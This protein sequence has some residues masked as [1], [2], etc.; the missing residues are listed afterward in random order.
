MHRG[1]SRERRTSRL[2][3]E[4]GVQCGAGSHDP[5]ITTW[6]EVKSWMP[7]TESCSLSSI[8]NSNMSSI[9]SWNSSREMPWGLG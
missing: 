2:L 1:R 5:E 6:A 9:G 7:L 3:A 4:H 8:L